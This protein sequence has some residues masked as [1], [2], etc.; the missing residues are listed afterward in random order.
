VEI[1][2]LGW[3]TA[4]TVGILMVCSGIVV[5]T[6]AYLSPRIAIVCASMHQPNPPICENC[7]YNLTG[8]EHMELCPEC[9]THR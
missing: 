5:I 2:L 4:G 6:G 3:G 8:L 1:P 9:G 7:G